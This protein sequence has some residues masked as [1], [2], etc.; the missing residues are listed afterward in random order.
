[1]SGG[2]SAQ[3]AQNGPV[4]GVLLMTF[5]TA[6]TLEDVPA[7]L[8]SVRGGRPAPD[9][10]VAEF[11]RRFTRVGGSP[12]IRI[13]REQARALETRLNAESECPT[14]RVAVGMRHAPPFIDAALQELAAA[15]A[16][17][18]VGVIL[19]PQYSPIILGGYLR[20]VDAARA[21]LPAGTEVRVAGAWH[22]E[23]AFLDALALRL[24]EALAALPDSERPHAPIVFTAHSLPRSVAA[25][26][27]EYLTQL[28]DTAGA[29]ARRVGIAPDRWQF[30]YQSAGHTPEPWLTPDVKDLFPE[31]Q[32]AGHHTTVVAPVQF[33]ADHLEVLYD[34]DV[35]AREQ[36]A[37]HGVELVRPPSLNLL[38]RFIDALAS[39]VRREAT[40]FTG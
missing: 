29:V 9:E 30:A 1:M 34:L 40:S 12:L 23:P 27:P 38:P 26:E 36:A 3:S 39:V 25:G 13:T 15:G 32:A 18:I 20:A 35:A 5:G 7:Y 2:G 8:A 10:L 31:L 11:Q 21:G 14:Y 4:R 33:L 24:Q 19:S 6:E 37:A 22:E 16:R 28:R 17:Q